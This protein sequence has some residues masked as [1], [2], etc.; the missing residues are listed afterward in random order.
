MADFITCGPNNASINPE[1]IIAMEWYPEYDELERPIK[2][3]KD[4]WHSPQWDKVFK[5]W[6]VRVLVVDGSVDYIPEPYTG[7]F[8]NFLG[9]MPEP[10]K[11]N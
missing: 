3:F 2:T 11:D 1:H 8:E 6:V 4:F 7:Y 5:R 9:P 10:P